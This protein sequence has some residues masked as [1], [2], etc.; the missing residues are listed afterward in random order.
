MTI[1]RSSNPPPPCTA[2]RTD[3]NHAEQM[4]GTCALCGELVGPKQRRPDPPARDD[5]DDAY[6]QHWDPD[7]L[8]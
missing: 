1:V 4:D 6:I 3:G 2:N 5:L 8:P 7:G